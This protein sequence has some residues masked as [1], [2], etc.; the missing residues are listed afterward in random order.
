[1][2]FLCKA[3]LQFYEHK[4]PISNSLKCNTSLSMNFIYDG[5]QFSFD[6]KATVF[7][8]FQFYKVS[9]YTFNSQL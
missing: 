6:A 2:I 8:P 4:Y 9:P 7:K 5:N 3:L 1:L